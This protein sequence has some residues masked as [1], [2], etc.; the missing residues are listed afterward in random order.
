MKI[1]ILS[2]FFLS[3]SLAGQAQ[4]NLEIYPEQQEQTVLGFGASLA[5][6][7]GWL[8]AHPRK[9]GVYEAIFGELSLDI[10]RV[11]NAYDYD[12]AMIGRVKEYMNAA[13]ASLG[14]PI[15]L[16]STSWGPSAYLKSNN[17]RKNG[18]TLRYEVVDGKVQ[19]DY[20]GFASWWMASLDEYESRGILPDFITIQNEPNFS[21]T[22]ESCRLDPRERI[23][24]QDTI[25]GYNLALQAVTDSLYL[26]DKQP[27]VWGP[28]PVGIDY[29]NV[30][31]YINAL[32]LDRIDAISHH[33]YHGVDENN[34]YASEKFKEVGDFHPEIPHYQTEYSRGDWWSLAGLIYKSFYDEK[35]GAYLYWDLIWNEGGLV[36]LENPWNSGSWSTPEGWF[37]TREFYSFKQFSAF[38]H[39]GWKMVGHNQGAIGVASLTFMSPGMD[40]ATCVLINRWGSTAPEMHVSIPGYRITE[41]GVYRTSENL[42]CAL[43]GPLADS[44]LVLDPTTVTTVAM[45]IEPYDPSEDLDAPSVPEALTVTQLSDTLVAFSWQPSTDNIGVKGYRIYMDGN[46]EGSATDTLYV[47]GGLEP[48][49]DYALSV[50]A[51]D[52]AG[53]ESSPS[54]ELQVRTLFIDREPPQISLSDSSYYNSDYLL[55]LS[56]KDAMAYVVPEY[57]DARVDV[58]RAAAKDSLVLLA[59]VPDSLHL[60][61]IEFGFYWVYAVDS[62]LN[63]SEAAPFSYLS[64]GMEAGTFAALRLYPNPAQEQVMLEF[65]MEEPGQLQF[66]LYDQLGRI[67]KAVDL[68]APSTGKHVHRLELR[69]LTSGTYLYW[70]SNDKGKGIRGKLMIRR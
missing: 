31:S 1:A 49:T 35:V 11:R 55:M 27:Q 38:I 64:T 7:E 30:Q 16:Y 56:D 25:A 61:H 51:Y 15:K 57:T 42:E 43:L 12:P 41:S 37:R 68:G 52:D 2:F 3:L 65:Q 58:I 46:L 14:H 62:V 28:E 18:G 26:R 48:D 39:P 53:N 29:N 6:Y 45:T 24:P 66:Y 5:Y 44:T 4:Y 60:P 22:W 63:V 17:D 8:N 13:E 23:T 21:A 9:A 33:L 69:D 47:L 54:E 10:L 32:D 40:S 36:T 59:G 67:L 19:F 34:P 70:I 20:A 50:S